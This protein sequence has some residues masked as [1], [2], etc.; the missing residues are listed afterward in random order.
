MSDMSNE[1]KTPIAVPIIF[2]PGIMGSRLARG[3]EMAWDPDHAGLGDVV[4]SA[5]TRKENLIGDSFN[6]DYLQV[7]GQQGSTRKAD[8]KHW[9]GKMTT[10]EDLVLKGANHQLGKPMHLAQAVQPQVKRGWGTVYWESYGP[11]LK[12]LE[13]FGKAITESTGNCHVY[14]PV[15]AYGYNWT[16]S[17]KDA[18]AALAKTI[19]AA[20]AE[21]AEL[22]IACK[23]V[24]IVS[25][26]MGGFVSRAASELHNKCNDIHG[27]CHVAMPDNG[28]PATYKRMKAGFKGSGMVAR[29]LGHT[30]PNVTAV[31]GH[32]PGGLEL[33]PSSNYKQA[34]CSA[35]CWLT[36]EDK[37]DAVKLYSGL[38]YSVY[39]EARKW[40]RLV[41]P[42]W[43]EPGNSKLGKISFRDKYISKSLKIALKFQIELGGDKHRNTWIIYGTQG[44]A[45]DKVQWQLQ[46]TV[47]VGN[48]VAASAQTQLDD[49]SDQRLAGYANQPPLRDNGTGTITLSHEVKVEKSFLGLPKGA[50][51]TMNEVRIMPPSAKGDGTVHRGAGDCATGIQKRLPVNT[52]DDHQDLMSNPEVKKHIHDFIKTVLQ[53][54]ADCSFNPE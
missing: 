28:S 18:G 26:S 44:S 34:D 22:K 21:M 13:A 31:L 8:I 53:D 52:A 2:V 1:P 54:F 23:K 40:W 14:L 38:P 35:D 19:D 27:I 41:N 16:A 43:L 3:E 10:V 51:G 6:K 49:V 42:K 48:Q 47:A 45:F 20:K 15:Y 46:K 29:V 5:E 4:A 36:L 7:A 30:G 12:H 39:T 24:I 25:H 33:L 17:N 9:K 37:D 11:F 50:T 32:A